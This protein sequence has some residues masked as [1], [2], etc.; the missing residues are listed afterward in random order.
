VPRALAILVLT[1]G[2]SSPGTAYARPRM[3]PAA[4]AFE[5]FRVTIDAHNRPSAAEMA[6]LNGP[7]HKRAWDGIGGVLLSQARHIS[8]TPWIAIPG[9]TGLAVGHLFPGSQTT[10]GLFYN[11]YDNARFGG[12]AGT[13]NH[14]SQINPDDI[15]QC[16]DP[17]GGSV[18]YFQFAPDGVRSA[19]LGGE[20]RKP[21][22]GVIV[23]TAPYAQLRSI[24][25]AFADNH[26]R[27]RAAA[28]PRPKHGPGWD[29]IRMGAA[30]HC[31]QS[32]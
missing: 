12:L 32:G 30:A 22:D 19:S 17:G 29:R 15:A 23:G 7:T 11:S 26:R 27:W 28:R 2:L 14:C 5:V 1:L 9:R 8:G 3:P 25:S 4:L 6:W 21:D 31:R 10:G 18:E 20:C 24:F 13:L 16:N